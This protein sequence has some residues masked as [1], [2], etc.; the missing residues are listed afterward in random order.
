M[1]NRQSFHK[2][3]VLVRMK[4]D[5]T[6]AYTMILKVFMLIVAIRV[7]DL[8]GSEVTKLLHSNDRLV[9]EEI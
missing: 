3:L 5:I 9:D 7:I 4:I 2:I 6:I 1:K 8:R